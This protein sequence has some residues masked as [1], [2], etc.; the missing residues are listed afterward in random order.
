MLKNEGSCNDENVVLLKRFKASDRE[1]RKDASVLE[2]MTVRAKSNKYQPFERERINSSSSPIKHFITSKKL[3]STQS[4]RRKI[5]GFDKELSEGD[6]RLTRAKDSGS[7]RWQYN[8]V[9]RGKLDSTADS[10][11]D[12]EGQTWN[13]NIIWVKGNCLQRDDEEPLDLWFRTVKQS[14]KSTV[15]RKESM[16]DEV[17]EEE[18]ELELVLERLGLSKKKRVDCRSNK[19]RK[20]QLTSS[21][22][23]NPV[24]PSKVAKKYPKKRILKALPTSGTTDSGDVI[25]DKRRRVEPSG[26]LG[27]KVAPLVK[28]MWLGIVEE[29]SE[30]KKVNVELEKEL[31]RSRADA[32]KDIKQLKASHVV[33]IGQLQEEDEKEAE[34][35]GV[36]DGLDGVSRQTVLDNQGDDVD[37]PEGGMRRMKEAN[38]NRE[39][40]YAKAHFRLVKLTQAV[41]DLTLQVKVKDVEINKGLKELA[42]ERAGANEMKIYRKGRQAEGSSRKSIGFRSRS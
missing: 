19:V 39:D 3:E 40:Q 12:T 10:Y 38:E 13:D 17:A 35:V 30:L 18:I 25:K 2:S 27:E 28:G 11:S 33:A 15:E 14:V 26:E 37:L 36:V 7:R 8:S 22:Q 31:A 20:A 4:E 42:E 5:R 34:T 41:S 21:A 1:S 24:K 9:V 32:L 29:K 16:L 23:P 6:K